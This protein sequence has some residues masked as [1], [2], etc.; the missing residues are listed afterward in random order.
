MGYEAGGEEA[1]YLIFNIYNVNESSF[2][3][4]QFQ[5]HT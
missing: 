4:Y 1:S 5:I 2:Q 3:K